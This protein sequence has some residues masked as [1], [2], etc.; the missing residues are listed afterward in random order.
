M[1]YKKLSVLIPAF[2]EEKTIQELLQRVINAPLSVLEKE[3]IVIDNNS[4]DATSERARAMGV[5]VVTESRPGKGAAL[6]RGIVEATGDLVLFQDA[7]LE[8][9]PNDYE[10]MVAPALEGLS[11]IVLGVRHTPRHSNWYIHYFGL[12]GNASITQ[13]TNWLYWNNAGEY[14]GCYKVFTISTLRSVTVHTDNFDFD[15]ELVCKLLKRGHRTVDVPIRYY[16]RDYSEGKKINWKH[17]FLILWTI[18]KY[19]FVD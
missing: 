10:A 12:L 1:A 2:N 16:P 18:L 8:Y 6:K 15:N 4:T 7:D 3:I 11:D 9:D 5:T 17:G 13:L 14:E 19:R